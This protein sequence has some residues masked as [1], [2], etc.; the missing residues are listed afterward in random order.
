MVYLLKTFISCCRSPGPQKVSEG[1]WRGLWRVSQGFLNC[2]HTCLSRR[3]L[4]NP[5]KTPSRTLRKLFQEGVEIDDV[6]GFP[7][8]K[9]QFQGPG[10]CSRK[11]KSRISAFR[12]IWCLHLQWAPNPQP[13]L[14]SL[15]AWGDMTQIKHTQIPWEPPISLISGSRPF[16]PC[17]PSD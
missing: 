13:N 12:P 15:C 16:W 6:L 7:G 11:W 4:P 3:T 17:F 1:F 8:L 2:P 5:F 9:N 10:S 14:H